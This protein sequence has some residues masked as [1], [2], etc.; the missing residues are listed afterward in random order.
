MFYMT[1]KRAMFYLT[2]RYIPSAHRNDSEPVWNG[3]LERIRVAVRQTCSALNT[4]SMPSPL[5][6]KDGSNLARERL[7]HVLGVIP[8]RP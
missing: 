4:A 1:N 5:K 6:L 7:H 3:V 8:N 2:N